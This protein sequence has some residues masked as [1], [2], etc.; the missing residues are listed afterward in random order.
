MKW[1]HLIGQYNGDSD[2]NENSGNSIVVDKQNNIILTGYFDGMD[3]NGVIITGNNSS[4]DFL[5]MKFTQ[6]GNI[7]NIGKYGY[8]TWD[9]GEG[10]SIDNANNIYFTGYTY[11]GAT[12][13]AFPS[14]IFIAKV[15][16]SFPLGIEDADMSNKIKIY[17]NPTHGIFTIDLSADFNQKATIYISSIDGKIMYC[18]DINEKREEVFFTGNKP[19]L[20]IIRIQFKDKVYYKKLLIQ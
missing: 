6:S 11:K 1:I 8:P 13:T 10:I 2:G 17:P 7:I 15:D 5:V 16:S 19:N 14:Y 20:Y 18:T 9:V 12:S 3:F 4:I